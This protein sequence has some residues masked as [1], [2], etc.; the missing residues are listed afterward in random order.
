M[1]AATC[2]P[3]IHRSLRACR[4]SSR[5]SS[6]ESGIEPVEAVPVERQVSVRLHQAVW[7]AHEA[8]DAALLTSDGL[9]PFTQGLDQGVSANLCEALTGL[10]ARC[11]ARE[12]RRPR[13]TRSVVRTRYPSR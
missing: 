3:Y 10:D 12:G 4:P 6:I 1:R 11:P 13:H 8:A 5:R 7:A 9:A 2:F